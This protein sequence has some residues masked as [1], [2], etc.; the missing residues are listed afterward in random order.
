MLQTLSYPLCLLAS[1]L[2]A[3]DLTEAG[4]G[5][6]H[7]QIII[8]VEGTEDPTA[9]WSDVWAFAGVASFGHLH[10]VSCLT[11]PQES[12]DIAIV[13]APFDTSVSYRPGARFGPRAIRSA[14]MRQTPSRSFHPQLGVNPYQNWAKVIDCGDIPIN[15]YDNNLAMAQMTQA[16]KELSRRS[17]K[18]PLSETMMPMAEGI[19]YNTPTVPISTPQFVT[20]GGDHSV[21]LGALRALKDIYGPVTLV[22]FDSHLDTDANGSSWSTKDYPSAWPERASTTFTHG[23][24]LWVAVQ[25]GLIANETSIHAGLRT[26]LSGTDYAD[27][28]ADQALG[29]RYLEASE[30]E[31]LGPRR[32]AQIIKNRVSSRPVYLSIDIDV[33][34]PAQAPGTGTPE[35]G[36][37]STREMRILLQELTG[38][39]I[40]GADVVEV[41]PAYD[42]SDITA[43]AA[44][45]I[46]HELISLMVL[47]RMDLVDDVWRRKSPSQQAWY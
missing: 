21:I 22:H 37:W 45:D 31:F 41:A 42:V 7:D 12:F 32:I 47:S 11:E 18:Y 28:D 6:S 23:S 40:I 38:L 14:S 1:C 25:E 19:S 13:G 39:N 8:D 5:R 4:T 34:D 24:M 15:P 2:A 30:M 20:L 46:V 33:L 3:I 16:F 29:F 9:K 27:Y 10:H 26:R 35:S 17:T 43:L 36:G 44:A